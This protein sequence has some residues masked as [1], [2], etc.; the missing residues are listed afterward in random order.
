MASMRSMAAA[1]FLT[2]AGAA[3]A[4]V[5]GW[6]SL[7]PSS[8]SDFKARVV[9]FGRFTGEPGPVR[10]WNGRYFHSGGQYMLMEQ[11]D[12]IPCAIG[13]IFGAV[14]LVERV[15]GPERRAEFTL[16]WE[17]PVDLPLALDAVTVQLAPGAQVSDAWVLETSRELASGRWTI[18]ILHD[19]VVL[20][21][22]DFLLFGCSRFPPPDR[23]SQ[24]DGLRALWGWFR[25]TPAGPAGRF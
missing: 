7:F 5:G 11:S 6:A 23:Q 19:D 17:H 13:V 14:F 15:S 1:S 24:L 25:A 21:S 12:E 4:A 9:L 10:V 2:A 18:S 20:A 22:Q 16:R 8:D 3:A